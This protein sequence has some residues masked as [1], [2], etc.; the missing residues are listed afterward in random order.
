M[1]K[2]AKRVAVM[3]AGGSGTRFW[4]LSRKERPKQFLP[5]T[6]GKTLLEETF[7]RAARFSKPEQVF[8]VCGPAHARPAK[9][10][11]PNVPPHNILVEPV[12]RNTAPAIGLAALHAAAKDPRSVVA[13]LPSDHHV[14]DAP[15]FQRALEQAAEVAEQGRIVTLGIRPT[16]PDTGFGYI[17]TG[18]P[19]EGAALTVRAFVEKP[20]AATARGYVASGDYVWNAGIFVFRADVMLEAFARYM[21]ELSAGL[22]KLGKSL[23]KRTHASALARVFPRLPSMSIDYGV[24]ERAD[25]MAVIPGDFGWSDVGAF[26]ALPEVRKVDGRGNVVS[27]GG[28]LVLDCDG[29]VA[30][31]TDRPMALV[32][33]RDVVAVDA[34]DAVLVLPKERSQDVRQVVEALQKRGLRQ[35]L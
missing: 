17:R 33:L 35:Y 3:L 32:G 20:D 29:C 19:L 15:G 6:G 8:V 21:P 22:M 2:A 4:P 18:A 30:L 26:S 5:L 10:L 9:K 28:A 16:R 7:R 14:A 1:A 24:A 13:V 34:G 31:A 11:L 12:P 23:G 25:N 27:G